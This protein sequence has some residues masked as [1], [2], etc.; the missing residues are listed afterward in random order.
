M[1]KKKGPQ[2]TDLSVGKSRYRKKCNK[3]VPMLWQIPGQSQ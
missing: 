1:L 3:M 2:E